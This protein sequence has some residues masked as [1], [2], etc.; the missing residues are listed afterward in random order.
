MVHIM[1]SYIAALAEQSFNI[2]LYTS[3]E[4]PTAQSDYSLPPMQQCQNNLCKLGGGET[5]VEVSSR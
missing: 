4:R 5:V 2:Q 3:E 1:V